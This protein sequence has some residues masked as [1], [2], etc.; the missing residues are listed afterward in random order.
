[1]NAEKMGPEVGPGYRIDSIKYQAI[2]NTRS[3]APS[4]QRSAQFK[5]QSIQPIRVITIP[6]ASAKAEHSHSRDRSSVDC[7]GIFSVGGTAMG[8]LA[9]IDMARVFSGDR[10]QGDEWP[11]CKD[12]YDAGPSRPF[13]PTIAFMPSRVAGIAR[14]SINMTLLLSLAP[15]CCPTSR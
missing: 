14:G 1:M 15:I 12:Y 8:M 2:L 4:L 5:F 13:S 3:S 7:D 6:T 9:E 10:R 11:L